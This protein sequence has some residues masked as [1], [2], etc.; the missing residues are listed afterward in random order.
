VVDVK[1][2]ADDFHRSRVIDLTGHH[3]CPVFACGPEILQHGDDFGSTRF[4]IERWIMR[5]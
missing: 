4:Y 5:R 3:T 2:L 1:E